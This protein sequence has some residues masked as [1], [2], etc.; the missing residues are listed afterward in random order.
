M[1][2]CD[3]LF[4]QMTTSNKVVIGTAG[5]LLILA[6]TFIPFPEPPFFT[7]LSFCEHCGAKETSQRY[8]W[9]IHSD[10]VEPS[11][12]SGAAAR[13]G[14]I[15]PHEHSWIFAHGSGGNVTCALGVGKKYYSVV[16]DP[17]LSSCIERAAGIYGPSTAKEI[18]EQSLNP[19]RTAAMMDTV[20]SFD[21]ET[22]TA[23]KEFKYWMQE[24]V[25]H[26]KDAHGVIIPLPEA[27]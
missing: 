2:G 15:R 20:G 4:D 25:E 6:S 10:K 7:S 27:L 14:L 5:L 26:L 11:I 22:T 8:I 9:F 16:N 12:L 17:N 18:Y 13:A 24:R 19:D 3:S 1:R 23:P 21:P